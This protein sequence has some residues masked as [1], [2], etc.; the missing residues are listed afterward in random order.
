MSEDSPEYTANPVDQDL[1]EHVAKTVA[2]VEGLQARVAGLKQK[3][4]E[5]RQDEIQRHEKA[6][7]DLKEKKR[8][9][10]EE[11][12]SKLQKLG[13]KARI[14]T[15]KEKKTP[16]GKK[17][18]LKDPEIREALS[19]WMPV[20]IE[21]SLPEITKHLNITRGRFE[22]F[23]EANPDFINHNGKKVKK[24]SYFRP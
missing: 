17:A 20:G 2:I 11:I 22:K 14:N 21:Q 6:L 19:S 3:Y 5:L 1:E 23:V 13:V 4:I 24:S 10:A 8:N 16:K 15:P 12:A 7:A 18:K 9:E